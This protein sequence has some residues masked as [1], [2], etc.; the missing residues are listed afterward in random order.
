[1]TFSDGFSTIGTVTPT[2]GPSTGQSTAALST[3]A[4]PAGNLTITASYSGDSTFNPSTISAPFTVAKANTNTGLTSSQNPS[5]FGQ[6]VTFTATVTAVGPGSGIPT[7]IVTFTDT[8]TSQTLAILT[9]SGGS[10]S[11]T[12]SSLAAG[13]HNIQASYGGDPNFNTST[14]SLT[15]TVNKAATSTGLVSSLNPSVSGQ[16]VTFTAKVSSTGGTPTGSITFTDQT[17]NQTLGTIQLANRQAVLTISTLA[18]GTHMIQASYSGDTNFAAS[19]T[20]LSQTV[21]KAAVTLSLVSSANP[22][23]A[24]QSVTFT[25]TVTGN[26]AGGATPTGSVTFVIGGNSTSVPLSGIT[27]SISTTTLPTGSDTITANY[28]GD[29]NFSSAS[30]SITQTVN[31]NNSST[32]LESNDNPSNFG[33]TVTLSA[34]VQGSL[35]LPTGTVTFVDTTTGTTPRHRHHSRHLASKQFRHAEH[36]HAHRRYTQHHRHLQRRRQFQHQLR[37]AVATGQQGQHE[38]STHVIGAEWQ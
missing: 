3:S 11:F 25:A 38:H 16:S 31:K 1:M 29:T 18:P 7:G 13:S 2:P 22:S 4:L 8:T 33:Q 26:A 5:N 24:G 27:A 12:I 20:T 37:H 23:Q 35:L 14:A 10:A 34:L 6:S 21:N 17:T 36:C 32:T 15:Q 30:Q 19:S 9:L 28:S